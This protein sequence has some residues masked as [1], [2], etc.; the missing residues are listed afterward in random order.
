MPIFQGWGGG[1]GL[2]TP[3]VI[4]VIII[5]GVVIVMYVIVWKSAKLKNYNGEEKNSLSCLVFVGVPIAKKKKEKRKGKKGGNGSR[6]VE[7]H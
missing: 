7:L 4:I 3:F 5:L 2:V 1:R 6:N